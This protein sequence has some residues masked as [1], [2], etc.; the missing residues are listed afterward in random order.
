MGLAGLDMEFRLMSRGFIATVLCKMLESKPIPADGF[1][2][3]APGRLQFNLRLVIFKLTG[4]IGGWGISYEIALRWMPLDL[5]D[6]KSTLAQ[7]MAW[8]HQAPSH[9]LSQ[10]WPRSM[11]SNGITRPQWVKTAVK[12]LEGS[13]SLMIYDYWFQQCSGAL[14]NTNQCR[15]VDKAI[16]IL[17]NGNF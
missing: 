8:C 10:C 16:R 7:V 12:V 11:S 6:D 5:I 1:N 17:Y 9:Y 13:V 15:F 2:S 14:F 4:V 3:L